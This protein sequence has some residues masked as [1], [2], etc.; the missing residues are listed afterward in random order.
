MII[1]GTF[2]GYMQIRCPIH[3]CERLFISYAWKYDR[4][5]SITLH[6]PY[7]LQYP[8]S[9]CTN[10]KQ[11]SN[12]VRC[13]FIITNVNG[14]SITATVDLMSIEGP[15]YLGDRPAEHCTLAGLTLTVDYRDSLLRDRGQ[16]FSQMGPGG[17]T[18]AE[19]IG[20]LFPEITMC[21]KVAVVGDHSNMVYDWPVKEFTTTSDKLI[22]VMY[23]Y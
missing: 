7:S 13:L 14:G 18:R 21:H 5:K 10:N 9:A 20:H 6:D 4:P 16:Q 1:F 3:I 19:L 17:S 22:V 11:Q 8:S 2:Q 12:I 23:A 15:D